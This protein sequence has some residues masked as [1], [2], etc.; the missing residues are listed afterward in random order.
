MAALTL[1]VP[2]LILI[3]TQAECQQKSPKNLSGREQLGHQKTDLFL[4]RLGHSFIHETT[5]AADLPVNSSKGRRRDLHKNTAEIVPKRLQSCLNL[6]S[7][8]SDAE[9]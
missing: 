2:I 1:Y 7:L 9:I 8:K 6:L 4:E 5:D 3:V